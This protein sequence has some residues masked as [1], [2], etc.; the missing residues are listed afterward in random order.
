VFVVGFRQQQKELKAQVSTFS[1]DTN[2]ALQEWGLTDKEIKIYR[3]CLKLGSSGIKR[4]S[5]LSNL[6]RTT[7]YDILN[8]LAHKGLVTYVTKEHVRYF[9]ASN[10]NFLKEVLKNKLKKIDAILPQLTTDWKSV[11]ERPRIE[12]FAGPTGI[13]A[14]FNE[15]LREG[16]EWLVIG[17][18]QALEKQYDW[19]PPQ[20]IKQ[21]VRAG[22]SIRGIYENS[23]IMQKTKLKDKAE[24]RHAKLSNFMNNQKGEFYVFGN[25][26]GMVSF[27]E[28]EPLGV[29]IENKEISDLMRAI[30]LQV[31]KNTP[32]QSNS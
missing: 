29:L 19:F 4:I 5:E 25:K 10:P 18:Q 23:E 6:P 30:F 17:N 12:L 32:E 28:R 11:A 26:V 3:I 8:S 13:K 21:R 9:E 15:I 24:L 20:I 16:K 1:M 31:W 2:Q 27:S 7:C 22:V 14:L